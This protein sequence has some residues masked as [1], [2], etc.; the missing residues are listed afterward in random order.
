ME[1]GYPADACCVPLGAGTFLP[2]PWQAFMKN[3]V[4]EFG[5]EPHFILSG[6]GLFSRARISWS[7]FSQDILIEP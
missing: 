2:G 1:K 6:K 7:I 3:S 5:D 4:N